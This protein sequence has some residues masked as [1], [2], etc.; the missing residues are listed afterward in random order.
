MTEKNNS[1]VVIPGA[2]KPPHLGHLAMVE[3]Y[4]NLGDKV[5]IYISSPTSP[6]SQRKIGEQIVTPQMSYDLWNIFTSGMDN[7]EVVISSEASPV[8]EVINLIGSPEKLHPYKTV[9]LGVSKKGGDNARFSYVR[10]YKHS[11]ID[12]K[13][14]PAPTTKLPDDYL[15]KLNETGYLQK[16]PS[17]HGKKDPQNYHASDLR[18]L[19]SQICKDESAKDLMGYYVGPENVN[20]FLQT[21]QSPEGGEQMEITESQLK[22]IVQEETKKVLEGAAPSVENS[23]PSTI[24]KI[25][26]LLDPYLDATVAHRDDGTE[27]YQDPVITEQAIGALSEVIDLIQDAFLNM[28]AE[29]PSKG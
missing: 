17:W 29:E 4:A 19:I 14:V 20:M 8:K 2:F 15:L 12:V 1:I 3:Y 16:L 26:S 27:E 6:K 9:Y 11:S 10:K 23:L 5:K 21:C 7:V 25:S 24:A 28:M 13:V 18:F 22:K